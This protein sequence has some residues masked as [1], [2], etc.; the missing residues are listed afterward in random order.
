M[1]TFCP[2]FYM[3]L[4]SNNLWLKPGLSMT[5]LLSIIKSRI[6]RFL[7][8]LSGMSRLFAN[9]MWIMF[10][11]PPKWRHISTQIIQV[12]VLSSPVVLI[13]GTFTGMVLA[14]QTY[15]QFKRLSMTSG[16]G[17]LVSLSMSNELGPVLA[18]VMLAGRVGAAIAAE[19]GT[20]KVTEQIDALKSLATNP[21]RYLVVPRLIAGMIVGPMLTALAIAV[22]IL[23]G[24]LIAVNYYG[25]NRAFFI[26]N[27]EALTYPSDVANGLIKAFVFSIIIVIVSCYKGFIAEGGAEGV[28]KATTAAVVVSCIG[29][30]ITDFFLTLVLF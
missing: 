25:V 14:A 29:I 28:G 24:Q 26:N 30:L 16:I 6:E 10:R 17:P 4:V 15:F 5:G 22:G 9:A 3:N 8:E 11:S 18:C 12:G 21:V 1:F 27:M 23:G 13:T 7:L 2:H 19:I 20:M